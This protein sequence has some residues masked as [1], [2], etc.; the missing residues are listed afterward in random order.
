VV[1]QQFEYRVAYAEVAKKIE[2]FLEING[3]ERCYVVIDEWSSIPRGVQPYFAEAIKRSFFPSPRIVLKVGTLPFQTRFGTIDVPEGAKGEGDRMTIGFERN[4]DIFQGID[5][6]DDLVFVK[7]PERSLALFRC[8]LHNHLS[9]ALEKTGGQEKQQ[10]A[11]AEEMVE[12]FFTEKA[13]PRLLAYA[14]GNARDFLTLFRKSFLYFR[15]GSADQISTPHVDRAAKDFALEKL[16]GIKE[17]VVAYACFNDI[18]SRVLHAQKSNGFLVDTELAS[19]ETLLFLVHNRVLHVWDR[20]Y[21]SPNHAGKRFLVLSIDF[22]ILSDH[23]KAPNYRK[24]FEALPLPIGGGKPAALSKKSEADEK[25]GQRKLSALVAPDKRMVRYQV[26]P[27]S[28]F[29]RA[30]VAA[31]CGRCD[32]TFSPEHPVAKKHRLCPLCG[33]ALAVLETK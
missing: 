24:L 16:D 31:R 30:P 33:E 18:V 28:F 19:N 3:L 23:L 6:D 13:F 12:A 11:S 5:L 25:T 9:Y 22:C 21:S 1:E 2:Q 29:E 4:G 14:H 26:L 10:A 20:S 7:N 15:D 27:A 8:L 17:N 32:G